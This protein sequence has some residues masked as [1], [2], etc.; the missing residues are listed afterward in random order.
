MISLFTIIVSCETRN[1]YNFKIFNTASKDVIIESSNKHISMF[2]PS[3]S[4]KTMDYM[5]ELENFDPTELIIEDADSLTIVFSDGKKL[6]S[7]NESQVIDTLGKLVTVPPRIYNVDTTL[8]F[9][10]VGINNILLKSEWSVICN[11]KKSKVCDY[12][13]KITEEYYDQAR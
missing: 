10:V 11:D 2:I 6:V 4:E 3:K 5:S 8:F 9:P 12:E 1:Q 7:Y 13:F